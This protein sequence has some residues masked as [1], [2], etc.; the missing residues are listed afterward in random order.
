MGVNLPF[1]LLVISRDERAAVHAATRSHLQPPPRRLGTWDASQ[2][3]RAVILCTY[4]RSDGVLGAEK[5][6]RCTR[7][8]PQTL[9]Q[10][11]LY[12]AYLEG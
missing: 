10:L 12:L 6:Y 2:R 5:R 11:Q 7:G 9:L 1:A 3:H 4:Y 8:Q